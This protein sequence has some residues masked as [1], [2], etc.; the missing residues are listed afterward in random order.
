MAAK[1]FLTLEEKTEICRKETR[2]ADLYCS[3]GEQSVQTCM[4][5][6]LRDNMGYSLFFP[7]TPL[8]PLDF[9]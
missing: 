7:A 9:L 2:H 5:T 8:P 3:E 4:L 6:L 1:S